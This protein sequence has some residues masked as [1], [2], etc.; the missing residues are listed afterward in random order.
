MLGEKRKASTASIPRGDTTSGLPADAAAR[1]RVFQ[2]QTEFWKS[3]LDEPTAE[4]LEDVIEK[5]QNQKY[6][7]FNFD[8]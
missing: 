7:L 8:L 2:L 3:Y 4:D 6:L 5:D 1:D